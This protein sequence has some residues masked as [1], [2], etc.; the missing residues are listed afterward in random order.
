MC[1]IRITCLKKKE[2]VGRVSFFFFFFFFLFFF[3]VELY[4]N[5]Q[6]YLDFT[7]TSH[8]ILLSLFGYPDVSKCI[9]RMANSVDPDQ[10]SCRSSLI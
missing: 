2:R 7:H 4:H 9:D 3:C 10:T 1:E 5:Y 8:K 6:I